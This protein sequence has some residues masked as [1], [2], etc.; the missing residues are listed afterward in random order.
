MRTE[1]YSWRLS[2]EL[3]SQLEAEARARKVPMS[4]VLDNAAR[5][6]LQRQAVAESDEQEQKRLHAAVLRCAGTWTGEETNRAS[7][8]R[9]IVQAKLRK[10]YGK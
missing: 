7:R 2:S 6:W 9:G 10:K 8:V 1:V 3:K 5:D 4:K